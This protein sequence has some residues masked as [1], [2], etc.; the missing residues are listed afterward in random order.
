MQQASSVNEGLCRPV[1]EIYDNL[2]RRKKIQPLPVAYINVPPVVLHRPDPIVPEVVGPVT[3]ANL[4]PA[5]VLSKEN[6]W[7]LLLSELIRKNELAKDDYLSWAAYH[8]SVEQAAETLTTRVALMPL[9]L[10]CAYSVTIIKHHMNVVKSATEYLNPGQVPVLVMDQPL[11][12]IA[13]TIQ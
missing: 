5:L 3:P 7:L 11:F 4:K 8:A 9:F 12:A 13:K 2:P 6:D 1:P 10:E